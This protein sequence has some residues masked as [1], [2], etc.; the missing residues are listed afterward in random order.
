[1]SI[2]RLSQS[3]LVLGSAVV[4]TGGVIAAALVSEAAAAPVVSYEKDVKPILVARCYA[5]H[6][7]GSKLGEFQI[8]SRSGVLTGG[9]TH[10]VV[11]IGKADESHLIKLVSGEI[12]GKMMPPKG[13]PLTKKE[14]DVLRAWIDQGLS[15]G[16]EKQ[17]D[18]W[19][20]PMA[21]RK[22]ALLAAEAGATHPI[23]RLL[24]PYYRAQKVRPGTPVDDRTYARRVYLDLVGLLPTPGE[25]E[26][27][28]ADRSPD[29]RRELVRRLLRDERNYAE[30]W[31]TFWNDALRNDYSGTGYIDGGRKQITGWLYEALRTNKP[32]DRFVA[33]LVDPTPESEG[34]VKGIVWRGVVN[35]SQTPAM[36]AAQGISQIFMGVNLKCASCHDS[37]INNWKLADAYGM[38]SIYAEGPL[39]MVRCDVPTGETAQIR[40]LYPQ[41]GEID[42]KAAPKQRREQLAAVL[43]SP[44]NGRLART[45]VNR[46]WGKLM[47]RALVEPADEMD[48]RPWHPD[49]LDWLAAD[50]AEHGYD[51][52]R[53]LEQIATSRAYQLPTVGLDSQA[54]EEFVFRGPVVKRLS[55]EQFVDAVSA[56]TGIWSRP[57]S[58]LRIEGGKPVVPRGAEVKLASGVMRNGFREIDVDVTGADLLL[59]VASDGGNG[60]NSDWVDWAEPRLVGTYGE[61]PLTKLP[62]RSASTG[63]GQVR[64]GQ[65]VVEQPLRLGDRTFADG[66]GTHA[67]SVLV[68]DLPKGTTRFRAVAGP[69]SGALLQPNA[70]TSVEL[71]VLTGDRT[72]VESRA[73]MALNDPLMRALGRPNREQ[74]VTQR[75]S[76]ATTLEALELTNGGTLADRLT[77]GADRLS[78]SAPSPAALV[79]KLYVHALSRAPSPEELRLGVEMVGTPVKREGVEDLLWALAMHPEMQLY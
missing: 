74:V 23:D 71:F 69:D 7:N 63:Y 53:L 12:P 14:V 25:L 57:A 46:L 50:F 11:K 44:K 54:T 78:E 8:D 58:Q 67:N 41:L 15:F 33:E 19:T 34:F 77:A 79:R 64:L 62:W 42:G 4:L 16:A 22:P 13:A 37:F 24:L 29:K 32:Y 65:N 68:Y 76:V 72:I 60:G 20:A 39:E 5:C 36:Q 56:L 48:A 70:Q 18:A 40:F 35:A 26:A 6:G 38:A 30:H 66:I 55:A 73:S 45:L 2:F 28:A 27:F 31:L 52:K 47:G 75:Q 49:L 51:V 9:T 17:G 59:L 61:Q 1:M 43:T 3:L 21:P 10:P